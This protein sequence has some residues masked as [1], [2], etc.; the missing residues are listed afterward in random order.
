MDW[1]KFIE[2]TKG[3]YLNMAFQYTK[4]MGEAEDIV[5]ET[6]LAIFEKEYYHNTRTVAGTILKNKCINYWRRKKILQL[7]EPEDYPDSYSEIDQLITLDQISGIEDMLSE[8]LYS[9]LHGYGTGLTYKELAEISGLPIGTIK[10]R[11]HHARKKIKQ[12]QAAGAL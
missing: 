9:H 1:G 6:Y 10:T 5:Q 11:I 7:C 8:D 4:H 3:L 12:A 2:E